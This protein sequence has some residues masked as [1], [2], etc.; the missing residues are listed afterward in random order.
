MFSDVNE[1][2]FIQHRANISY[3]IRLSPFLS[4][5]HVY[6]TGLTSFLFSLR[7]QRK[8][9][10]CTKKGKLEL[11]IDSAA[12]TPSYLQARNVFPDI[13]EILLRAYRKIRRRA[14]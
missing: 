1:T 5:S 13:W 2:L 11:N 9:F 14:E 12:Y 7:I 3:Y 8:R 6:E 10:I 4:L